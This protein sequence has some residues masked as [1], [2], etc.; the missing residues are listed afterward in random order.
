MTIKARRFIAQ[1]AFVMA[2]LAAVAGTASAEVVVIA[3]SAPPPVRMEAV[4][5]ARDGYVWDRG[6]W[7]WDHGQYM[8][9]PGHWEVVQVGHHWVPG[10]W[11][12]RGGAWRWMPAHWA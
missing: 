5:P 4:P 10:H 3:P 8:W 6:H 11:V 2:G 1:A 12:A 7:R 9:A